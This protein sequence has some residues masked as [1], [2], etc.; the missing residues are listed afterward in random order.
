MRAV[1]FTGYGG[2]DVLDVVEIPRPKAGPGQVVVA[3]VTAATNPGACS[4]TRAHAAGS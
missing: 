2:P 1:K 3:V 4:K